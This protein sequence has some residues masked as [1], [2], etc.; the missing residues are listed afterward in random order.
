MNPLIRLLSK[1]NATGL[2]GTKPYREK[3]STDN[4]LRGKPNLNTNLVEN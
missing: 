1:C 4:G 2:I 3:G